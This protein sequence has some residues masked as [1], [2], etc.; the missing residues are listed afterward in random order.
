M[1]S[2]TYEYIH[3]LPKGKVFHIIFYS[4]YSY[5]IGIQHNIKKHKEVICQT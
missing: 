1:T 3:I 2:Q 5:Y 4:F